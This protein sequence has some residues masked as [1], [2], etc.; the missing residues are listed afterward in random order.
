MQ[1]RDHLP[2]AFFVTK[3]LISRIAGCGTLFAFLWEQEGGGP[4]VP[5]DNA[6]REGCLWMPTSRTQFV[7]PRAC[8]AENARGG[9]TI[10][11]ATGRSLSLYDLTMSLQSLWSRLP[12]LVCAGAIAATLLLWQALHVQERE[13]IAQTTGVVAESVK[14]EVS[15]RMDTR[16][17]TLVQIAQRWEHAGAP[18]QAQWEFEAE[19]NLHQFPGYQAIIWVDPA[20]QVR[21]LVSRDTSLTLHSL[22]GA[23][24]QYADRA[25]AA[26]R[27]MDTVTMT[28]TLD[29]V[30]GGKGFMAWVPVVQGQ[31][32]EGFIVGIFAFQDL[33]DAILKNIA[34]G[35]AIALFDGAEEIYRR[36]ASSGQTEAEWSRETTVDP[37]GV[38]WRVRIWPLPEELAA[39]HSALP[40]VTLGAGFVMSLLLA[41]TV[42]LA[43]ITRTRAQDLERANR[44]LHQEMTVR[45]RLAE[46]VEK[47]RAELERRVQERT[48]EL[49]R[50]NEDLQKENL[51]RKRAETALARQAQELVRSNSELE[52]FA[53]VAS[54]DLQEPLRKILAF[55]DRLNTKYG[56]ELSHQGRDY[57]ERMQAAAA[58]MQTLITDLLTLSRVTTRPQSF[59]SVDLSEIARTVVSDMEVHI[60]QLRGHVQIGQLPSSIDADPMQMSQ[61]LQNLIGNALKFHRDGEPPVVKVEGRFLQNEGDEVLRDGLSPQRCQIWVEDNGIGFDEKYLD[62]IF[63]PFQRLHG[64]GKYE[65]TGMGLAIC[66]KIVERHE[67]AITARS[68]P[69]QGTTFIVILPVQQSD[70]EAKQWQSGE[71]PSRF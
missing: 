3:G 47:A 18:L 60:Q 43:R 5:G 44:E 11:A 21:W 32:V 59:V 28:R 48:A 7:G 23:L 70:K 12:I 27:E 22:H 63:D 20:F 29:A 69:G 14:S 57:L 42:A 62:R 13:R 39:K 49:A 2:P 26:A 9:Y 1:N 15:T 24:A 53:S 71:Y 31:N 41:W 36:D 17:L 65:G 8:L 37:Y 34:P 51:E 25:F 6:D 61:L 56:Q 67:G 38:T 16:I 30:L 4:G 33:L 46:E 35:Y 64:R 54:H 52:Q 58:R 66:R 50:A 45:Q 19:L 55:G 10:S 68:A 40:E